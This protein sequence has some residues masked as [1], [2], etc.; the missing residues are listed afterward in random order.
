MNKII[1]STIL[2]VGLTMGLSGLASAG[3]LTGVPAYAF[4]QDQPS[5][6]MYFFVNIGPGQIAY[7]IG[8]N[9][10]IPAMVD[11]A[12]HAKAS[13]NVQVDSA[14]KITQVGGAY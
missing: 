11:N 4:T 13:I 9:H 5:G 12:G 8:N 6:E 3:T 7:Y 14:S 2:G 1:K 10:A